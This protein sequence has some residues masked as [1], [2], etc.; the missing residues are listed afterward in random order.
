MK[1]KILLVLAAA[2]HFDK[3]AEFALE[4]AAEDESSLAILF[5]I[6][7]K[8]ADHITSSLSNSAFIGDKPTDDLRSALMNEFRLR[9]ENQV[10]ELAGV[11]GGRGID[12]S[13]YIR[14]GEIEKESLSLINN[15]NIDLVIMPKC[16]RTPLTEMVTGSAC[17]RLKINAPCEVLMVDEQ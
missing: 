11:A 12:V 13:T 9:A 2:C 4:K 6:D 14:E 17:D 16:K 3:S 15:L 10:N 5:I 7:P 8:A 1:K